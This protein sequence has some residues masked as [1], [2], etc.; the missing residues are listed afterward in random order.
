[1]KQRP[2][3]YRRELG[4]KVVLV[5]GASRGIGLATAHMA[6]EAGA[7]VLLVARDAA[8]LEAV[9]QE[10]RAAGGRAHAHATD[11]SSF[12]A[13]DALADAVLAQ[14]G[15][16]DVL[17]HNAARSIRRP[18]SASLDRFHDY[19]RTMALNYFAP[20]RLT[21]RLLPSLRERGGTIS[22]VL[23]MGVLMPA[24]YFA[25]Y[26]ATKGALD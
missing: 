20:V 5:T 6:A 11:L 4:G 17:I 1:M 22:H 16:V 13:I 8:K 19:E 12:D 21:L 18:I 23:T 15:G 10:I 3:R 26:L 2:A 14:Y 7:E 24:P 25:A 9:A